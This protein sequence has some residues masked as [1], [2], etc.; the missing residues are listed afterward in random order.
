MKAQ[1]YHNWLICMIIMSF[2]SSTL[3]S[4]TSVKVFPGA[5]KRT[6]SRSEYESWINNT[7]EGSTEQ[8]TLANLDFFAWL[9]S[10][11]GMTLD[12]YVISAGA[13]DKAGWIRQHSR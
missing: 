8:Q 1:F 4:Q 10:E 5:D 3:V 11:Y 13:I 9:K 7:N 12:I 6:P 2:Y